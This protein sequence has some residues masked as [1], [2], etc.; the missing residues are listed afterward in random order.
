MPYVLGVD[1]GRT[2]GAAAVCRRD[3]APVVV[4]ADVLPLLAVADGEVVTGAAALALPVGSVAADLLDHVGDDVPVLLDGVAYTAHDLLATLIAAI[5][6]RVV[7][8]EGAPPDRV[9]VTHPPEWGTYRRGLFRDALAAA[10]YPGALLLPTVVAAAEAEHFRSPLSPGQSLGVAL[11]GGRRVEYALLHRGPTAFDLAGHT[12]LP[13]TAGADLDPDDAAR[14]TLTRTIDAFRAYLS[15]DPPARAVIA[16]GVARSPLVA[17]LAATLPMPTTVA[18]DPATLPARGAALA[19]RP[20]LALPGARTSASDPAFP[21]VRHPDGSNPAFRPVRDGSD[22]GFRPVSAGG[23]RSN[24]SVG[25][26]PAFR[27]VSAGGD[28]PDRSVGSD[29][30]FRPV[31]A[32]GDRHDRLAGSDPA[33]RPVREGADPA[34]Q[35]LR[36]GSDPGFRPVRGA[37]GAGALSDGG[38]PAVKA[39]GARGGRMGVSG[40]ADPLLGAGGARAE[41]GGPAGR[42]DLPA[43]PSR[44]GGLDTLDTVVSHPGF[45]PVRLPV[46]AEPPARPPV[47]IKPLVAPRRR[48][49][50]RDR[51]AT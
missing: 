4:D 33:F 22:P 50:R 11:L 46:D 8:G 27:P 14:P 15:A 49:G 37:G 41:A 45:P 28:R 47:E 38:D 51:G 23:D 9:A 6:D 20:R 39:G 44:P 5:A 36:D 18:D 10:G 40:P 12:V 21:P 31:G 32:G 34:F 19:A 2:R 29:P 7:D 3:G 13:D 25:S 16:G 35:E 48:F 42:R 26:D 30:G 1:V 43:V 17:P 24:R